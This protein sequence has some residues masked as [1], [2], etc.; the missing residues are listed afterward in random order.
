[1][2]TQSK[3]LLGE[4]VTFGGRGTLGFAVGAAG[5]PDIWEK[6]TGDQQ[7]WLANVKQKLNDL[8]VK[9]TDT[10]CATWG[11]T[12]TA[13]GSIKCFQGWY[14]SYGMDQLR[15]DG[16]LDRDTLD[17]LIEVAR[18]HASDGY[19]AFPGTPPGVPS[20]P[21]IKGSS[22]DAPAKKGLSTGAIAGIA[23]GVAATG[24]IIY[25]ATRGGH[26]ARRRR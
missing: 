25:A 6:L 10:Q 19:P 22:T 17:A 4:Q 24:G 15:T 20:S 14:N 16:V 1:M 26:K 12:A 2:W 23:A 11:P 3:G 7:T 13:A 8:I 5:D 21:A 9:T 18:L